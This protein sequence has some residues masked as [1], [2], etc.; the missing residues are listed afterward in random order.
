MTNVV[1]TVGHDA[2]A[3]Q[4]DEETYARLAEVT[5]EPAH[6]VVERLGAAP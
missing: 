6:I 1:F 3:A 2:D 5:Q 4:E